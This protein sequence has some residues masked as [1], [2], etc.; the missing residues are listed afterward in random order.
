[1]TSKSFVK[2]IVSWTYTIV[3]SFIFTVFVVPKSYIFKVSCTR[4]KGNFG[5]LLGGFSCIKTPN[6]NFKTTKTTK[7]SPEMQSKAKHHIC[8]GFLYI[9]ENSRQ[10]TQKS[11][12]WGLIWWF[13]SHTL[14]PHWC[15]TQI[16]CQMKGL[17]M[18]HNRANFHLYKICGSWAIF[19]VFGGPSSPKN[20]PISIKLASDLVIKKRNTVLN[21]FEKLQFFE[22]L[23]LWPWN[24]QGI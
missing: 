11:Y 21:F 3:S 17:M 14:Q 22:K 23:Y 5:L 1:M 24:S 13:L 20:A 15:H 2:W 19:G 16:F 4:K 18:I 10:W 12:F 6:Q 7:I 8:Y 9:L